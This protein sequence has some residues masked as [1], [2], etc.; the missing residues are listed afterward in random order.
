VEIVEK[1]YPFM[2]QKFSLRENSGGKG[3]FNGGDG[4]IREYLFKENLNL[5]VLTERRVFSPYGLEEGEPG[6]NG[7]NTLITNDGLK[8]NLGSK[9]EISVKQ[10]DVFRLETPGGGAYGR[11]EDYSNK[12]ANIT[13]RVNLLATAVG[14]GGSLYTHS[15]IQNSA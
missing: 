14:G 8:I 9:S 4:L 5:C 13:D 7:I 3:K 15:Q 11:L 1:R 6:S 12:T 10:G 2:I